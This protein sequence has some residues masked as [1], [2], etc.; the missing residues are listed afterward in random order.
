MTN[1]NSAEPVDRAAAE[2]WQR[3]F[4]EGATGAAHPKIQD[5]RLEQV[6]RTAGTLGDDEAHAA[7]LHSTIHTM[8]AIGPQ[9]EVEGMLASQIVAVHEQAMKCLF[10]AAGSLGSPATRNSEMRHAIQ[11]LQI[12]PRQVDTL[13]KVRSSGEFRNYQS[14]DGH[15]NPHAPKKKAKAADAP[16]S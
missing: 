6:A 8:A 12:F 13:A 16:T 15:P 14:L 1:D 10:F 5:Q 11:L 4:R 7:T 3:A 2:E 9:N